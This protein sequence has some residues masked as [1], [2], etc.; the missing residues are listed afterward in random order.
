MFKG[1]YLYFGYK[2]GEKQMIKNFFNDDDMVQFVDNDMKGSGMD[3]KKPIQHNKISFAKHIICEYF[4]KNFFASDDDSDLGDSDINF[5]DNETVGADLG[6]HAICNRCCAYD[7]ISDWI[8]GIRLCHLAAF[9]EDILPVNNV[10]MLTEN[11]IKN[12]EHI[13]EKF[14]IKSELSYYSISSDCWCCT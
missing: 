6:I 9:K 7:E 8:I 2:I 5:E 11:D 4:N 10:Y 12:L 13:K 1:N 14:N 3:F